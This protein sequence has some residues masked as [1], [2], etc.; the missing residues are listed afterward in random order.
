MNIY[1]LQSPTTR[2][3]RIVQIPLLLLLVFLQMASNLYAAGVSLTWN[4]N[5]ESDL[6]GDHIYQRI[7]TSNDYGSPAFS[8]L[9]SNPAIP[10]STINNLL[11]DTTYGFIATAFDSSGNESPTSNEFII[12]TLNNVGGKSL[13]GK[14]PKAIQKAVLAT[15]RIHKPP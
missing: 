15:M 5:N 14:K 13:L 7:L 12:P 3:S 11:A 8:G 9:P 4:A 1:T 6:A 10:Q 2:P